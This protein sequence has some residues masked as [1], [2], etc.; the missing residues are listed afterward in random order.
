MKEYG[1]INP[2]GIQTKQNSGQ[3]TGWE[4]TGFC[5]KSKQAAVDCYCN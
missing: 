1:H 2:P 5:S 4:Q 3:T